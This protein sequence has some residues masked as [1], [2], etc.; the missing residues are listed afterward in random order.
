MKKAIIGCMTLSCI[1]FTG[2]NAFA[3][4]GQF[5]NDETESIEETYQVSQTLSEEESIARDKKNKEEK[6]ELKK[7]YEKWLQESEKESL[8]FQNGYEEDEETVEYT[9]SPDITYETMDPDEAE[10]AVSEFYDMMPETS[11]EKGTVTIHFETVPDIDVP[12]I[13]SFRRNLRYNESFVLDKAH[14][15]SV[16]EDVLVGDYTFSSAKTAGGKTFAPI[17]NKFTVESGRSV[18]VVISSSEQ[19]DIEMT[20]PSEM[21]SAAQSNEEKESMKYVN[22]EK[23]KKLRPKIVTSIFAGLMVI[24]TI[25]FYMY[26]KKIQNESG[27]D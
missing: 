22:E 21:E 3:D 15:Y 8:S 6:E 2:L 17:T 7:E 25:G 1:L 10:S 24:I 4:T 9:D 19:E 20:L 12:V 18:D 5:G 26:Y 11:G 13:V 16:T 23:M 14:D 27:E